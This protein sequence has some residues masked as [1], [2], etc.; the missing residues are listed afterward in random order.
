MKTL[1]SLF[2]LLPLLFQPLIT[3]ADQSQDT[4]SEPDS[5]LIVPSDELEQY[6]I[7]EKKV[8][9]VYP[10][11]SLSRGEQG[12]VAIGFIIEAD[13]TTSSHRAIAVS[14]SNNFNQTATDAAKKFLYKPS[15]L[16]TARQPVFTT[17]TFTYQMSYS[18]KSDD[19]KRKSLEQICTSAATETLKAAISAADAS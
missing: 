17:N 3:M 14:R 5:V 19:P 9:P 8:A 10:Q 2:V 7:V 4:G 18:N 12:C 13:G 16:N 15:E 11:K 1:T 6:W